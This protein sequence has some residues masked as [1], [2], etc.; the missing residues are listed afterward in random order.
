MAFQV[1]HTEQS[2]DDLDGI[3]GYISEE[4]FNSQAAERFYNNVAEIIE[5]L[6]ENPYIFP[7]YHDQKTA[8]LR[9]FLVELH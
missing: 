3:I 7:L 4:L 8:H 9:G 5:R 6:K 1:R 2:Y